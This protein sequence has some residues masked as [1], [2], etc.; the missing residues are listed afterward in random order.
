MGD[1]IPFVPPAL[2]PRDPRFTPRPVEMAML[3][4]V[5]SGATP[6]GQW[7]AE[8]KVDGVRVIYMEGALWSREGVPLEVPHVTAELMRL[9]RRFGERMVLDGEFQAPGGFL[10]TLS[11][12]QGKAPVTA[13]TFHLFDALPLGDWRADSSAEPLATRRHWISRA[14]EGWSPAHVRRIEARPIST[15]ADVA[16]LAGEIWARGGEG[17]MLKRQDSLYRRARS[18]SWLKVKREIALTGEIAEVVPTKRA[19]RVTIAGKVVR[20][21][22]TEQQ[23][24]TL[25]VGMAVQIEAMEWTEP[26]QLRHARIVAIGKD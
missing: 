1:V 8:E 7:D 4:G 3:A 20:I 26:G 2:A 24:R 25:T 17:L 10:P 21:G 16:R 13:G 14:L 23:A 5:W 12:I 11:A 18:T 15:A 19:A 6:S 9:E 22:L